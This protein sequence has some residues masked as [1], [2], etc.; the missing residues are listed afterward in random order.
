M[1]CNQSYKFIKS[2]LS[3]IEFAEHLKICPICSERMRLINQTMN[4]LDESVEVPSGLVEKVLQRKQSIEIKPV[5]NID[6]YKY[7][8]LAAVV[9][10]GIFL[11][12]FLGSHADSGLFISKKMKKDRAMIEYLEKHH[13]YDQNSFYQF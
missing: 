13:L 1:S 11:G 2:E 6:Y 7:L 5:K 10:I 8:Q 12:T 4:L 9:A 3:N